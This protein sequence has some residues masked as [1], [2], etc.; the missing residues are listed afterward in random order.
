MKKAILYLRVRTDDEAARKNG[1]A[2]QNK[3]LRRYCTANGIEI[4]KTFRE[5]Y[6]AA[7]FD[8]PE[9][10]R[11]YQYL[12]RNRSGVNLI[13]FRSMDR[14]SRNFMQCVA[15]TEQLKQIGVEVQAVEENTELIKTLKKSI[16][17]KQSCM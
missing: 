7:T 13:L 10:K 16:C 14:F 6:S 1:W 17:K 4:V 5:N 15:I 9:F 12:K 3:I 2:E 11:S 8:R